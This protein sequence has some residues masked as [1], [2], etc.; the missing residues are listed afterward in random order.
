MII[1]EN[2]TYIIPEESKIK[3]DF[4]TLL[5]FC[6]KSLTQ[7]DNLTLEEVKKALEI[8]DFYIDNK[9]I[10]ILL[11]K[12]IL[13]LSSKEFVQYVKDIVNEYVDD[14]WTAAQKGNIVDFVIKLAD[15]HFAGTTFVFAISKRNKEVAEYLWRWNLERLGKHDEMV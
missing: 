12:S 4:N 14:D 6:A 7:P 5:R 15:Y 11:D 1:M 9:I 13:N 8:R 3:D 2:K 10:Y